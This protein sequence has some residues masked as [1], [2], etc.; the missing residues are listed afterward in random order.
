MPP[1]PGIASPGRGATPGRPG[2]PICGPG[3]AEA[4]VVG[5]GGDG[6]LAI[7]V[8]PE[9]TGRSCGIA[10]AAGRAGFG[11]VTTG[12]ATDAAGA[13][14]AAGATGAAATGAAGAAARAETPTTGR[15][16]WT[17]G[18]GAALT[19]GDFGAVAGLL[20]AVAEVDLGAVA[21]GFSPGLSSTLRT[22]SA[23]GSGTTLS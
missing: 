13:A 16:R 8:W 9:G 3:D 17:G 6:R 14:E 2:K 23:I 5:G 11:S 10:S 19:G 7:E 1:W 22:R 4:P 21:A 15:R 12:G 18:G 20:G